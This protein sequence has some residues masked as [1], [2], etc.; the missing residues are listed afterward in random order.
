ML[1]PVS[2]SFQY[3]QSIQVRDFPANVMDSKIKPER[4]HF[5]KAIQHIQDLKMELPS[6]N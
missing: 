1:Y 3:L 5:S 4:H 2:S 6:P